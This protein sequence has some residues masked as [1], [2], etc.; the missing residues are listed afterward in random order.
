MALLDN[1]WYVNFGNGSTTGYYAVAVYSNKA[2]VAG[3]LLRQATAPA[4][5]S[6][7][8]FVVT[9]AGTSTGEPTWV[10]TR[11]AKNSFTGAG[12]CYECTGL[13]G[14]NG[15]IT[16]TPRWTVSQ[17]WVQGQHIYDSGTASIQLCTTA[18]AGLT[19]GAPTFSAT[20]G[21]TASDNAAVWT[22]CGLASAFSIWQAPHAR[23]ASAYAANWGQAGNTFFVSSIHAETQASAMTLLAPSGIANAP[24]LVYCVKNAPA[25]TP[26]GS[27]DLATTGTI[28]TTGA[29]NITIENFA[30]YNGLTFSAGSSSNTA[31]ILITNGNANVQVRFENCLLVLNNTSASSLV[32]FGIANA[33]GFIWLINT[34]VQFGAVGQSIG[35]GRGLTRWEN[36]ASAIAGFVPTTLFIQALSGSGIVILR[37]VDLSAAGS[38]KTLVSGGTST[39][40]QYTFLDCKLGASVTP[41]AVG[42][43]AGPWLDIIRSDSSGTNYQQQRYWYQGTLIPETTIIRTSGA[44]DGTT[45]LSWNI[46]TTANSQW[47]FPFE[48][49]PAVIWNTAVAANRT[50]TLHGIW[51]GAA[52]PNND[53]IWIEVEYLGTASFP[54]GVFANSTKAN[55]LATGSALTADSTSAWGAGAAAYQ[56]AH[57][58]GAFTGVILAGNA[59]PQ[60]LWFMVSHSGTGTSGS[61]TT[62]FNGQADGA[63]VTDNSG[64][65]QIV[66]QAMTRFSMAV[67]LS[68]PQP[69][70]VGYLT[71]TVKAAMASTTFYI[72][73][74]IN[75]S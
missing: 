6:E 15:D 21:V 29:F 47:T 49:F 42:S 34:P 35:V 75:Q 14:F 72:D 30:Y 17:T 65:N 4:V 46:T 22:S 19:S 71:V 60:Q 64:A 56:T 48:S 33:A 37:G 40:L 62:I 66:W 61:V 3:N 38:G 54:L 41:F 8:V 74:L 58:Y 24:N 70:F 27:G 18:G 7:R 52:V 50:I 45:G 55:N 53:N 12:I 9:T 44:S 63:Q 26:P 11:G 20:A 43:G 13:S 28:S 5:G 23:L 31:D 32:I 36:T 51:K 69:Q 68:S 25:A 73:P 57:A 2:W 1:A 16:N 67:T 59:S 39:S 10:N